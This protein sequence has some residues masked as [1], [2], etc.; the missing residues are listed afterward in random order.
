M[1]RFAWRL[2]RVLDIRIRQEQAARTELLALT[3]KVAHLRQELL[4]QEAV[5][6]EALTAV[7]KESP[8]KRVSTQQLFL[9]SCGACDEKI[10]SLKAS[11]AELEVQRKVK[12]DELLRLRRLRKNLEKLREYARARFMAEQEKLD[13]KRLDETATVGFARKMIDLRGLIGPQPRPRTR[14]PLGNKNL[15]T[16]GRPILRVP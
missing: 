16:G 6:R 3:E 15:N 13:Q 1:K 11:L 10:R 5:V 7:A 2:Q 4:R 14:V 9:K 8:Q 12:V